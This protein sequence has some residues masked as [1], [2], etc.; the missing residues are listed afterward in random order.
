MTA[1]IP[2][3]LFQRHELL[4][5][6]P[7]L[8]LFAMLAGCGVN[9]L[10]QDNQA[11]KAAWAQVQNEYQRRADLVPNL[12]STV[13]GYAKHESE[14][15]TAVTQAR[16]KATSVNVD[17]SSID[18]P[19]KLKHYLAAQNKLSGALGRLLAVSERYPDLKSSQNFLTLQSQLEG[20]ENRIAVARRD[21][22]QA[23]QK[24]NT[25][26]VTFP[27]RIWHRMLY[28]DMKPHANFKATTPDADQAPKVSF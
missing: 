26:L 14:T 3:L 19:G 25:D 15:L 28:S 5:W 7:M 12:V 22:I 9:T 24:Y 18:D 27:T 17:A 21:Y 6:L 20:T 1:N 2:T 4:R 13:K 23:V 16:A 11:V 8:L 10:P